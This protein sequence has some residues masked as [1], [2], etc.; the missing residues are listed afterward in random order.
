[1]ALATW[2]RAMSAVGTVA[3][4]T[5]Y[6]RRSDAPSDETPAKPDPAEPLEVRLAGVLVAA[7]REAFDRDR[8]RFDLEQDVH[9]AEAARRERA[10]R[11]EWIR[12]TGTSAVAHATHLALLSVGV[13][14]AS[15]AV[16]GWLSPLAGSAK[17]VL[18][19]GWIGLSATVAAAVVTHQQLTTWLAQ[20][21]SAADPGE[22]PAPSFTPL[23]LPASAAQMAL[24]WLFLAGFVTTGLG[25]LIAL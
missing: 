11:L 13:W 17:I 8:A 19:L 15:V 23:A 9:D 20:G 1:M 2:L 14:G 7:L 4:A 6:F 10:L 21:V 12:Q 3:E 16:A 18:G 22:T 5:R 24:P 25:L